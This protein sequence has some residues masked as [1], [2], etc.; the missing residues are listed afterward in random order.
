LVASRAGAVAE[1]VVLTVP[2]DHTANRDVTLS[3]LKFFRVPVVTPV[4]GK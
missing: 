3:G 4:V 2:H 1:R